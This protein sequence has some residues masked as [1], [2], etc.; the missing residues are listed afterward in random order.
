MGFGVPGMMLEYRE[1]REHSELV[2]SAVK[3]NNNQEVTRWQ[4]QGKVDIV[5]F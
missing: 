4:C 1:V 3:H 5:V 2:A